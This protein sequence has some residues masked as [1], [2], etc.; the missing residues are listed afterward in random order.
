[1]LASN[2]SQPIASGLTYHHEPA[3]LG[4]RRDSGGDD[5]AIEYRVVVVDENGSHEV[6]SPRDAVAA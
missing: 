3:Q 4:E 6:D 5:F 2:A 1:M